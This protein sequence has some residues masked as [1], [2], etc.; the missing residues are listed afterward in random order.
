M[1]SIQEKLMILP[2]PNKGKYEYHLVYLVK[3]KTRIE[4]GP[5]HYTCYVDAKDATLLMRKNEVMYEA[6][7]AVS[8]VSGDLYT[9]HPY[10]PSSVEK[11][12][13]LKANNP[14][15]GTNYYTDAFGNVNI[16]LGIGT[17]IRYKLEGLYS[18]VQT[19]GNT[20]DIYAAL[21]ASNTISFDNSN[22]TIQERTAYW[23]VNEVHDHFFRCISELSY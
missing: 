11:L 23:A 9:T 16:P 10:N 12:K 4:E 1:F 21:S 3:F 20:P 17:Q 18:D 14:T 8:S 5:A 2:I 19:N 7:P 13:H 15:T 6:P 22:S